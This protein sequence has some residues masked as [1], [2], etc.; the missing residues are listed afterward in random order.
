MEIAS[1]RLWNSQFP[2]IVPVVNDG[3]R[4]LG[5]RIRELRERAGIQ[6]QEL[7]E[8]LGIDPSAMSNI[9]RGKR[10]VK[11]HEL[12]QVAQVLG[13]SPLAILDESS[14]VSRLPVAPRA[15]SGLRVE[16]KA[17]ERLRG[18]AELNEV[19]AAGGLPANPAFDGVPNVDLTNWIESADSLAKWAESRLNFR[20]DGDESFTRLANGIE[21]E[22]RVDVCVDEPGDGES[23]LVG[24][25]ITDRSFPL[26]FVSSEQPRPRALFTLAHELAHVLVA[27]G[28]PLTLD[29]DLAGKDDGERFANTFAAALLMPF[30]VIE[31][32][33]EKYGR[34]TLVLAVLIDT[35]GVSYESLVYRLHNLR[36]IN[37]EGRDRLRAFGLQGV[38]THLEDQDLISRLLRRHVTYP[39]TRPPTWLVAR[40]F[41]AFERGVVSIRPLAGLLAEEPDRLLKQLD[42]ARRTGDI[43]QENFAYVS[44]GV[45]DEEVFSG[46]PV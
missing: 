40:A 46:D 21:A 13:V 12:A 26:I 10:G 8:S 30:E 16:G 32:M 37:A 2:D 11:A 29:M 42:E 25:A 6:S 15:E 23:S 18:L 38:L 39:E 43:D 20:S 4:W 22:L 5:A 31:N 33:L 45:N 44:E 28:E 3:Q 7:A 19:L 34:N 27:D 17:F 35:L 9:E 1:K 24:A 36:L 14:L 41:A